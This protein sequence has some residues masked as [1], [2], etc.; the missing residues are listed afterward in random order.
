MTP[1]KHVEAMIDLLRF[2]ECGH[3]TTTAVIAERYGVSQRSAE[4]WLEMVQKF[5][6][7]E[8]RGTVWAARIRRTA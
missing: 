6:P 2:F 5:C 4:R 7:L 3:K 1:F 8:R